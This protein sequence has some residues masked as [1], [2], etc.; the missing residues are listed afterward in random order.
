MKIELSLTISNRQLNN[1]NAELTVCSLN[2][3]VRKS[4]VTTVSY[5]LQKI[6]Y[7]RIV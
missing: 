6:R 4:K 2:V 5:F 7:F 1:T 3:Q